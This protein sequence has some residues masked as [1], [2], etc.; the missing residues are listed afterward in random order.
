[1]FP[2]P[3]YYLLYDGMRRLA[4]LFMRLRMRLDQK[5]PQKSMVTPGRR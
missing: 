2:N 5:M 4:R 3:Y 1:M